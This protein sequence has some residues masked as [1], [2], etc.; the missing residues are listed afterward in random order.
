MPGSDRL[1]DDRGFGLAEA[2]FALALL[3]ILG[4]SVAALWPRL[5]DHSST[6][7]ARAL[8]HILVADRVEQCLELGYAGL[9]TGVVVDDPLGD[10]SHTRTTTVS[11][12]SPGLLQLDVLV[13]SATAR[14]SI[15]SFLADR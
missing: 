3:G 15:R 10:G 14:D 13:V 9:A 6:G 5:V 7:R 8:A 2:L 1:T 12:P 11:E 4:S